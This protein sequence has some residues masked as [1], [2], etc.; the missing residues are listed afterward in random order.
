MMIWKHVQYHEVAQ[1]AATYQSFGKALLHEMNL[2]ASDP[3]IVRTT[4]NAKKG[5][6]DMTMTSL[7]RCMKICDK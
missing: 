3:G 6:L 2:S 5:F 4:V 7:T 1:V